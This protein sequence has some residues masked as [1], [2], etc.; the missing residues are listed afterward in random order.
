MA[1]LTPLDLDDLM[2]DWLKGTEP[3]LSA[4]SREL[5]ASM[6]REV[7]PT[8]AR[9]M[10]DAGSL[11]G[12]IERIWED[13]YANW[14][15]TVLARNWSDAMF[16]G[17]SNLPDT[18]QLL[19]PA[20]INAWMEKRGPQL[21]TNLTSQQSKSVNRIIK[22]FSTEAPVS[23]QT[24]AQLI[25]PAVGMT[26]RQAGTLLAHYNA[27]VEADVS[28]D[29]LRLSVAA[30]SSKLQTA[31]A[32][33][34]ARTELASAYNGGVDVAIQQGIADDVFEGEIV[35]TWRTQADERVCPICGPL[36]QTSVGVGDDFQS[37]G[38][39]G[40]IPPAHPQCRCVVLYE[41]SDENL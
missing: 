35:K 32:N 5:W 28:G 12:G 15:D 31:R 41:E 2:N 18:W 9:V 1:N 24:L 23:A 14:M 39:T 19:T 33:M 38:F 6:G 3:R 7:S 27:L 10:V 4:Q 40:A 11:P 30:M 26:E 21:F 20:N 13:Q 22:F 36:D 29:T 17:Q 16:Q 34:I 37:L 25:K 8:I